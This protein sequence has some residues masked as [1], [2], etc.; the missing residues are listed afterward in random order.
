MPNPHPICLRTGV[1]MPRA[2]SGTAQPGLLPP[3]PQPPGVHAKGRRAS[4]LLIADILHREKGGAPHFF[5]P[6]E[7]QASS[8]NTVKVTEVHAI[9]IIFRGWSTPWRWSL[10]GESF[11]WH[12][13]RALRL[14]PL[15]YV[16]TAT[17][18]RRPAQVGGKIAVWGPPSWQ[19]A[20]FR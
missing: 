6:S 5:S 10:T 13:S 12:S 14:G 7:L 11:F 8:S 20:M 18:R 9:P 2:P 15:G 4:P 19:A 1:M 16:R 17:A 3:K